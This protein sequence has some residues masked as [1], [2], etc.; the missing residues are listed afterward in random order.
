MA[1]STKPICA[2][3][4]R[5][6]LCSWSS[7]WS[8]RSSTRRRA[9]DAPRS[10][11]TEQ[12]RSRRESGYTPARSL[13]VIIQDP[14]AGGHDHHSDLGDVLA[15]MRFRE[16]K[17]SASCSAPAISSKEGGVVI[18][19][20]DAREYLRTFEQLPPRAARLGAAARARRR[21]QALRRDRQRAGRVANG[22][23]RLREREQPARRRAR[24]PAIQRVGD[25]GAR[26]RRHRA[27]YRSRAAGR[28][29][30][31]QGRHQRPSR[32]ASASRSTR[33]WWR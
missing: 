11:A 4:R 27:R 33:R 7:R 16:L 6:S 12:R 24:D 32:A 20:S 5:S 21:A 18:L 23:Q 22:A 25:A 3:G 8:S 19:P 29:A 9:A 30:R 28:G 10:G 13:W 17:R 14:G 2:I 26:I 31:R 1:L 15:F